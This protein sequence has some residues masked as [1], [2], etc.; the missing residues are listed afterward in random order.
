MMMETNENEQV[1]VVEIEEDGLEKVAGGAF[2]YCT[3]DGADIHAEPSILSR[4]LGKVH[5]NEHLTLVGSKQ[6]GKDGFPWYKVKY[7]GGYGWISGR[8][9]KMNKVNRRK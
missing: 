5:K 2:V 8:Y 3:Y 9:A 6:R 7:N 4:C 1:F